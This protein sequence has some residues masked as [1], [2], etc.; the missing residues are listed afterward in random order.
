MFGLADNLIKQFEQAPLLRSHEL[1]VADNVDKEH[2]G[3]LELNFLLN[4]H[5]H[6]G[7]FYSVTSDGSTSFFRRE[8]GDDL[9]WWQ[10]CRLRMGRTAADTR[11]R[12]RY[13]ATRRRGYELPTILG[14]AN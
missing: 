2:I 1:G 7:Q 6:G 9:L 5:G 10:A 13:G 14:Q 8:G 12:Q 4:F 11:L 3:D